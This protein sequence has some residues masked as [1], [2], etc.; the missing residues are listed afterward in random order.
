M[1]LSKEDISKDE[2]AMALDELDLHMKIAD[3]GA[4]LIKHYTAI[5]ENMIPP[6]QMF[7]ISQVTWTKSGLFNSGNDENMFAFEQPEEVKQ[8]N[9][10]LTSYS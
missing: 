7:I 9:D 1:C 6:L 5:E 2:V 10:L 8:W 4:E 3:N